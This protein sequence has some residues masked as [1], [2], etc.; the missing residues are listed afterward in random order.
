MNTD[1]H[2]WRR[3]ANQCD[4]WGNGNAVISRVL[5]VVIAA[6][7]LV[8]CGGPPSY[9]TFMSRDQRYFAQVAEGCDKLLAQTRASPGMEREIAGNDKSLPAVLKE[10]KATRFLVSSNRVYA[11]IGPER[12]GGFGMVWEQHEVNKSLWQLTTSGDGLNK[13]VFSTKKP[14]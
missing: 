13:V 2:G 6:I 14:D 12:A 7:L 5:A 3:S 10:I 9:L 11:T 8:S 4:N 1:K